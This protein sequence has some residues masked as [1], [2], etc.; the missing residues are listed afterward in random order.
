M[1]LDKNLKQELKKRNK[2]KNYYGLLNEFLFNKINKKKYIQF[3]DIFGFAFLI[4][5]NI[6]NG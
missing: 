2:E 1:L 6:F 4:I 3:N 5:I